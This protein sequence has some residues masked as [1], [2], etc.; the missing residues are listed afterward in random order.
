MGGVIDGQ[1]V[2]ASVTNSAF[3][4]K[5]GDDETAAKLAL[6]DQDISG[7]SGTRIYNSQRECN[8]LWSFI[9]GI[10]NQVKTYLPTWI[11]NRFGTAS[12]TIKAR[13]EAID[14]AGDKILVSGTDTTRNYL[15]AKIASGDG[16]TLSTLYPSGNEQ[17]QVINSDRGSVAVTTHESTHFHINYRTIVTKTSDYIATT[18]DDVIFLNGLSSTV[19]ITFYTSSGNS[20]RTLT[21]VCTDSTNECS[22]EST[23]GQQFKW[24]GTET[25]GYLSGVGD[26]II[27]MSD[28]TDWY[29]IG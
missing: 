25:T 26:Y 20:G 27:I 11:S 9:G 24:L 12:D 5:N 17:K 6:N 7:V 16:I 22:Y 1:D 28:G 29:R 2:N 3:L 19:K 13:I 18:S 21:L 14:A 4:E 10:V 8:A 15:G 23:G